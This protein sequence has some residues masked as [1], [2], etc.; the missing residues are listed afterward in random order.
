VEH[1]RNFTQLHPHPL[2]QSALDELRLLE[3]I[4]IGFSQTYYHW[5]H[6]RHHTGNSDR[7]NEQGDTI[8]WL[9]IYRRGK[10]DRPESAWGYT[11]LSFFR[12][13]MGD[14]HKAF[15]EQIKAQQQ[16]ARV[17]TISTCHALGFLAKEN[18]G[19][20]AA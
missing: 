17:H 16:V 19:M 6:M 10:N 18:Q 13:S 3:S 12:D 5:I 2:F 9:S 8:D 14:V 1:Q 4:A 20:A 15:H 11:F 7:Q